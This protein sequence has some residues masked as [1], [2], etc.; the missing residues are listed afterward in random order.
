VIRNAPTR[1][2]E[3]L[4]YGSG[5]KY[6]HDQPGAVAA[7]S[8]LPEELLGRTFYTPSPYGFEKEI[9]KRIRWFEAVRRRNASGP[10]GGTAGDDAP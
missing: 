9:T 3:D 4:G 8:Y 6:D 1:L 2:M 7:Q 10:G 5:Y